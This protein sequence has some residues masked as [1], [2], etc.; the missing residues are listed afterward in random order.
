M[1]LDLRDNNY[2]QNLMYDVWDEYFSDVPRKNFVIAKFGKYS[3]RQLGCIKYASEATRVK[4]L[5]KKYEEDISI[6]DVDSISIIILT[7]YF[8]NEFIPEYLLIST[9]A[10]EMCHYTHGFHS[11]LDRRYRYPHKGG[12]VIKEMQSRGLGGIL[13]KSERWLKDNWIHITN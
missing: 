7:R 9:L 13:D 1:I 10:H 2:L 11:P 8:T 4:S 3:K 5:L 12:V 6:Q